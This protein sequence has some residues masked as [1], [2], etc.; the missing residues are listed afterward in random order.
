M[1]LVWPLFGALLVF[2]VPIWLVMGATSMLVF[3]SEG[4]PLVPMAQKIVDELNSTTLL[5]VPYFVAAAV[6]MERGNVA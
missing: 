3:V 4:Q 2:G 5:A 1:T 6:F